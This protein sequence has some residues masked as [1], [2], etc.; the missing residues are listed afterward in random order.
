M[1]I[2]ESIHVK[3]EESNIFVK[4]VVKIDFLVEDM[5]KVTLKDSSI[6][7]DKPKLNKQGEVQAVEVAPTLPL[8]KD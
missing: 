8:L 2:E 4:N 5:E 1:T 3:F 6:Q 7:E